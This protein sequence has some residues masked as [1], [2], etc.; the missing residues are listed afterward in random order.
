[1]ATKTE[2]LADLIEKSWLT[3]SD[4]FKKFTAE[5][6][7]NAAEDVVADATDMLLALIR[8]NPRRCIYCF[9]PLGSWDKDIHDACQARE[10][11]SLKGG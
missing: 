2:Q 5:L 3:E 9:G 4:L 8:D 10:A 7:V 1:M 6:A 11:M